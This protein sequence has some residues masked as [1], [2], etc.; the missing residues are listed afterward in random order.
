MAQIDEIRLSKFLSYVLRHNPGKFNLRMDEQGF[1][2]LKELVKIVS[3]RYPE[4]DE[5]I[6][7]DLVE[8]SEKRRFEIVDKKIRATY[9]HSIKIDLNLPEIIP[10]EFLYHGTSRKT[11]E[12]IRKN[13]LKPMGRQYVHLS[14]TEEDA[15]QVGLRKDIKPVVLKIKAREANLQGIKFFQINKIY[16]TREIPANFIVSEFQ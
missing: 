3:L 1:I 8:T 7:Q 13:G 2:D 14:E 4:V 16:L 11:A 10:P 5:K 6:I 15:F 9:G 12:E